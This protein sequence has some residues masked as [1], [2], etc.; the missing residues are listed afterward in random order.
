MGDMFLNAGDAV[1]ERQIEKGTKTIVALKAAL[2]DVFDLIDSGWLIRDTT[3]DSEP[4]WALRQLPQVQRLAA[5]K[6]LMEEK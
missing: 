6:K 1:W 3:H 5:A 4:D 2:A